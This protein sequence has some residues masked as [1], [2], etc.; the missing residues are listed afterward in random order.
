MKYS[1]PLVCLLLVVSC[2]HKVAPGERT[3]SSEKRINIEINLGS[4]EMHVIKDGQTILESAVKTYES[5][6]CQGAVFP[7]GDFSLVRKV[8]K[9]QSIKYPINSFVNVLFYKNGFNIRQWQEV[10]TKNG[11]AHRANCSTIFLKKEPSEKLFKILEK[12][13]NSNV[14]IH[15]Q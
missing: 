13:D 2:A 9:Y 12:Y 11:A 15:I 14:K 8:A 5:E 3:P 4:K 10:D 6:K 1:L 7:K